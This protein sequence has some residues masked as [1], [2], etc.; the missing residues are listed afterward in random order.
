MGVFQSIQATLFNLTFALES[1]L[2]GKTQSLHGCL[3]RVYKNDSGSREF[4]A[5][6]KTKKDLQDGAI[7]DGGG[8][9]IAQ[10]GKNC[11]IFS[12]HRLGLW[13]PLGRLRKWQ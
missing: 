2:S 5:V 6:A 4:N 1:I 10:M 13:G 7:W 8:N 11:L 9:F 3:V 12:L